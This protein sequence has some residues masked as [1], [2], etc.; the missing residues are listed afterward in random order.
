MLS[1][2]F[3]ENCGIPLVVGVGESELAAGEVIVRTTDERRAETRVKGAGLVEYLKRA[4][5]DM[6]L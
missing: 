5:A 1:F 6:G 2:Q 3:A 4:L